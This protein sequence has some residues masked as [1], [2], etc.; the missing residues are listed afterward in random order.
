[1]PPAM[2]K[3]PERKAVPIISTEREAAINAVMEATLGPAYAEFK[4]MIH[5]IFISFQYQYGT[6]PPPLFRRRGP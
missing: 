2:P 3:M 4:Y 5:A 1:M 6:A